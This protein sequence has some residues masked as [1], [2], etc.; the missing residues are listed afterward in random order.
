MTRPGTG[1]RIGRL[2]QPAEHRGSHVWLPLLN[3][4]ERLGVLDVVTAE[5]V[6]TDAV[7][8]LR[9]VAAV[10]AELVAALLQSRPR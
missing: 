2:R 4:A 1:R 6:S 8:D 7:R 3:G 9:T 5:P 10:V